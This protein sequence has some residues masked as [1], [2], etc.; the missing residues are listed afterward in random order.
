MSMGMG[1]QRHDQMYSIN[2]TLDVDS[3]VLSARQNAPRIGGYYKSLITSRVAAGPSQASALLAAE[4]SALAT[5]Q[6]TKQA[7][8]AGH[9]SVV[10]HANLSRTIGDELNEGRINDNSGL[11]QYDPM[12][13]TARQAQNATL[14]ATMRQQEGDKQTLLPSIAHLQSDDSLFGES[15]VGIGES[16][17]R[18]F[19]SADLRLNATELTAPQ[20]S[21]NTQGEP[22]GAL[23]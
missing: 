10:R 3:H 9:A 18:N 13:V 1:Q 5:V 4:T 7:F 19:L 22:T 12:N 14:L 21:K 16:K 23:M 6:A 15:K 17:V 2:Y 11:G 8:M 20:T